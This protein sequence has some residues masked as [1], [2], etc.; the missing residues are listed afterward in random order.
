MKIP[1]VNVWLASTWS[2]HLQ[3]KAAKN[4]MDA[5][6]DEI[7]FCRVTQMALLRLLTNPAVTQ[8]DVLSRRQAWELY[9]KLIIDPRIR[10]VGEPQGVEVLWVTLSKRDNKDH[11]LWTDDYLAA[12]AQ[13]AGAEFVTLDRAFS[14]RYHSVR[15]MCLS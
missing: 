13:A 10:L 12:F 2:R 1:D 8:D 11:L 5:E 3:H 4:W 15:V 7:A 9:D 6:Q 14:R